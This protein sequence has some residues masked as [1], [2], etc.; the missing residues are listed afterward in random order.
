MCDDEEI[1]KIKLTTGDRHEFLGMILD[2]SEPGKLMVDVV[3]CA[4]QMLEDWK[5][6]FTKSAKTP[7]AD[8]SFKINKECKKLNNEKSED[9]HA[10][11]SK[12]S[13][14]CKRARPDT[15]TAIAF[16]TTRVKEPDEDNFKKINTINDAFEKHKRFSVNARSR[17]F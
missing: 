4:K 10:F 1:G 12:N 2:H 11:A 17:Q 9:F 3:D 14:S 7:A 8:H 6:K 16:L 15:Q 13:F 5:Y